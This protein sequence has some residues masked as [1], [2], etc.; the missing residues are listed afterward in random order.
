MKALLSRLRNRNDSS[1]RTRLAFTLALS[2][3]L[4]AALG[5]VQGFYNYREQRAG[6]EQNLAHTARLVVVQYQSLLAN[7]RKVLTTLAAQPDVRNLSMPA[8]RVGLRNALSLLPEYDLALAMDTNGTIRCGSHD[9]DR[10][11]VVTEWPWFQQVTG[12]SEFTVADVA[13]NEILP[14][15]TLVVAIPVDN[16]AR[17]MTGVLALF[18]D[19]ETLG[20]LSDRT[21]AANESAYLVLDAQGNEVPFVDTGPVVPPAVR[22]ALLAQ[23]AGQEIAVH[24]D[25]DR[26]GRE[27]LFAIAAL[28]FTGLYAVLAQPSQSLFGWFWVRLAADIASPLLIW[29]MAVAIAGL[30]IHRLVIRW[31]LQLRQMVVRFLYGREMGQEMRFEE[32]PHELKELAESFIK[33]MQTIEARNA[34]LNDAIAHRDMLIKEIHHRVK[35]NLQIISSLLNLQSRGLKDDVARDVLLGLQTRVNALA[36]IHQSLY[37]TQEQQMVEL[38]GFLGALCHQLEEL[39]SGRQIYVIS[40]VPRHFVNAETAVTLAMLVTEIVSNATKHAFKDQKSGR[41]LVELKPGEG[42]AATLAV[43]DNGV[44]GFALDDSG[45]A[46]QGLGRELIL[47]YVRQ[48][49]GEMTVVQRNGT[50]VEITFKRLS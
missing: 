39:V 35:N 48:L 9:V 3:A 18:I 10:R 11:I 36:L 31:M 50:H 14:R 30:A 23:I 45:P 37:E 4:P 26:Q 19:L 22:R 13:P 5:I 32:A 17:R 44:G 21:D 12:G 47:G 25:V 16:A 2:L 28:P 27:T 40:E 7:A 49:R 43:S 38:Q 33:M 46:R 8:C 34:Q 41:V 42:G 6:A 24:R 20:R 29:L 15:R 1:L